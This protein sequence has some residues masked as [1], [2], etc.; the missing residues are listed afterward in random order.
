MIKPARARSDAVAIE[1]A[2]LEY[3]R[4]DPI[5][6]GRRDA[7]VMLHPWYGCFRFWDHT[8][9]ALPEYETFALDLYSLGARAGWEKFASPVGLSRAVEAFADALR[10]ERFTVIGNSMGGITAQEL[11]SR[12]G[13]RISKLILVGTGARIIGV[14]PDWREAIDQWIAAEADRAF[15]ERMVSALLARRPSDHREFATFVD[16]VMSANKAFMG[17]VLTAAFDFDLRPA[18]PRI[19]AATLVIRGEFD[20]ARTPE[21]VAELMAGIPNCCAHEIPGAGHSPQ[22]DSPGAFCP[23]VREFLQS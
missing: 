1:S 8:V 20:A 23:L 2:V 5:G 19:K 13:D 10:L 11:A 17:G 14:K 9:E 21:H 7:V 18:L 3:E 16:A 12:L 4:R 22:V 6:A 15:T